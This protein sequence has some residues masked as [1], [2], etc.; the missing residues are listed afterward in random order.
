M[1]GH[2][3]GGALETLLVNEWGPGAETV[4]QPQRDP[5]EER[6]GDRPVG[7]V[8]R[9]V[10]P[11]PGSVSETTAWYRGRGIRLASAYRVARSVHT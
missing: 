4:R 10:P 1:F 2:P 11:L 6:V 8:Q 5:V 3:D 9:Q 7:L